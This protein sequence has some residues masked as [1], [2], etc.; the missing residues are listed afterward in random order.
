M[1]ADY[2]VKEVKTTVKEKNVIKSDSK[3]EPFTFVK[4]SSIGMIY[5]DY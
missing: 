5:T 3:G 2:G 1:S 4:E